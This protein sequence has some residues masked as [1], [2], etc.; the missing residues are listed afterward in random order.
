MAK[1][2]YADA[3]VV[4]T[5]AARL[6]EDRRMTLDE[7]DR[8]MV[9]MFAQAQRALEPLAFHAFVACSYAVRRGLATD[10]ELDALGGDPYVVLFELERR[11][12]LQQLADT[13]A[14]IPRPRRG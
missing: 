5:I 8:L 6:A 1:D 4:A 2:P 10:E 9:E 13:L 7:H 3:P 11:G 12:V 14:Q